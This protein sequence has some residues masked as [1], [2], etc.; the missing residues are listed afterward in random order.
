M[1]QGSKVSE[2]Q[3][4]LHTMDNGWNNRGLILDLKVLNELNSANFEWAQ[5]PQILDMGTHFRL[6]FSTRFFDDDS[7]PVSR[8]FFL[9]FAPG[10]L[11]TIDGIQEVK[12][13][14]GA[15]GGFDQ[16]G[17]FPFHPYAVNSKFFLAL[18]SGWKRM[19]NVDIDMSIGQAISLDGKH[20]A[21]NG[22]GPLIT[23]APKEPFLVGDPFV[24]YSDA[25][26]SL[27]YIF[28]TKWSD[29]GSNSER[30]YKIGRMISR[31][32]F[33]FNRVEPGKQ[34]I[35]D[36]IENE[37]QAM[38]SVVKIKDAYHM[39]YCYRSSFDFRR[40]GANGYRLGHA[41]SED[42]EIWKICHSQLPSQFPIW[43][44]NMQCYPHAKVI[45]N[46]LYL[47]YNGDSFGKNGI[48]LMTRKIEAF[49]VT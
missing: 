29:V 16:H 11:E 7:L 23:S 9:D 40:G 1:G 22:Y 49:D 5:G 46:E 4:G 12:I 26:Y 38:P 32:G 39:F 33:E 36:S 13:E 24:F 41:I 37:A 8:V 19:E 18:T 14:D 10:F 45:D 27:F 3:F 15:I 17:I 43:A 34:I 48:G 21:R 28:G 6:Y 25:A 30:T 42:L 31:D 2:L 35:P 44:Q 20:F 47:F